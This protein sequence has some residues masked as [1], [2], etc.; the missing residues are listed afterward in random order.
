ME[1]NV[2]STQRQRINSLLKPFG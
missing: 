2:A 1:E